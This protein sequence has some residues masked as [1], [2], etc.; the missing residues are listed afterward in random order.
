MFGCLFDGVFVYSTFAGLISPGLEA[1]IT[2]IQ[3]ETKLIF[4]NCI[5]I[6]HKTTAKSLTVSVNTETVH[7]FGEILK[8]RSKNLKGRHFNLPKIFFQ[9]ISVSRY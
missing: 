3:T 1:A 4:C 8:L 7:Y 5:Q 6:G 9:Y 2:F